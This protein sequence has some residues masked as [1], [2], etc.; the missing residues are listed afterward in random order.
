MTRRLARVVAVALACA[1]A[2]PPAFAAGHHANHHRHS[3][4]HHHVHHHKHHRH[5]RYHVAQR[6]QAQRITAG[7]ADTGLV[8]VARASIGETAYQLGVRPTLWC[9]A[10]VNKWLRQ[11]GHSPSGSDLAKSA[12]AL[13]PR[14]STPQ[15]GTLAVMHRRGGGHVGVVSGVTSNGDPIIISGNHRNRV[16]ESVYP[17]R[18]IIAYVLPR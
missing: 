4:Q 8:A 7:G 1:F 14:L 12:L 15:V 17:R 13:G 2:S 18:R 3:V 10:A 6:K 5:H 11:T 16:Q 9:M